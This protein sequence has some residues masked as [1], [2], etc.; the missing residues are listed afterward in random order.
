MEWTKV[1]QPLPVVKWWAGWEHIHS[2]RSVNP[3]FAN[4]ITIALKWKLPH[5]DTKQI[6]QIGSM[7]LQIKSWLVF[8][9]T[10]NQK[11][12]KENI[13]DKYK[14]PHSRF[15]FFFFKAWQQNKQMLCLGWCKVV[16]NRMEESEVW[17]KGRMVLSVDMG[18]RRVRG[19]G[20]TETWQF[21][22]YR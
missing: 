3:E 11:G 19:Q 12:G 4:I 1:F 7:L 20:E 14:K 2:G 5:H 22:T 15:F 8:P 6:N 17:N 21:D 16:C 18:S 10:W 13:K 9:C